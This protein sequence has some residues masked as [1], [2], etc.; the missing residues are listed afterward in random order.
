MIPKVIH[1]SWVDKGILFKS[2]NPLAINGVQNMKKINPNYKIEISDDNDIDD[3]IQSCISNDDWLL[4][5][6]R[7]IVERVDLWRL[8]KIYHEGGIYCDIDRL[9]NIPF[10]D[11][12]RDDDICI[13][14]THFDID[15]SQDLMISCPKQEIHNKAIELSMSRRQEGCKD[16]MSLG[17]ISY[18]HAITMCLYG[19][20]LNRF[21]HPALWKKLLKSVDAHQGYRYFVEKPVDNLEE[22]R[23]I[24]YKHR[25]KGHI[26]DSGNGEDKN[27][28]YKESK[29]GH[30]T[31]AQNVFDKKLY[32]K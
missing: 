10:D 5:K 19:R 31:T 2:N 24:L 7:H 15:F 30:W 28:L 26:Y 20:Q 21:L 32:G 22:H 25:Y 8:L 13:L 1:I 17:P 14:P 6:D 18:F 4:I 27:A 3:Y 16:V 12:I 23:T 11:I 29:I 9:C